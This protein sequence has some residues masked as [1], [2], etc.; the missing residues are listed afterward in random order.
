MLAPTLLLTR[1]S[2]SS[3]FIIKH[4][5]LILLQHQR[6]EYIT[7]IKVKPRIYYNRK[8]GGA[9]HRTYMLR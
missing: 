8:P 2:R 1:P 3:I 9:Y 7:K 6:P 4:F 5:F